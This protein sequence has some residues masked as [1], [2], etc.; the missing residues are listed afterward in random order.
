MRNRRA[1]D[2]VDGGNGART[3]APRQDGM[4]PFKNALTE[5][6]L[7]L[8]LLF[9]GCSRSQIFPL[10]AA[11]FLAVAG[12]LLAGVAPLALKGMID[13]ATAQSVPADQT[14]AANQLLGFS[15]AYLLCLCGARLCTDLRPWMLSS[16]EQG[17]YAHLRQRFFRHV[18]ALPLSAHLHAQGDA[19]VQI[20]QQAVS[21]YQVI[22]FNLAGSAVPILA[23]ALAASAVLLTLGQPALSG[24]FATT[25]FAYLS[26]VLIW[27]SRIKVA[28]GFVSRANFHAH[29]LMSDS[30]SNCEPLKCFGAE[31]WAQGKFIRATQELERAWSRLQGRRLSQALLTTAAFGLAMAASLLLAS[32]AL[33][34]GELSIGGFFLANLYMVQLIRLLE[35]MSSALRD[36]LQ[37]LAFIRPIMEV[38]QQ[39]RE[40]ESADQRRTQSESE[41]SDPR[42][43]AGSMATSQPIGKAPH[44]RFSDIHMAF[45]EQ[46]LVLDGLNLDIPAG[47]SIGIVGESGGGKSSLVRVLLR[48]YIPQA[49]QVF[50]DDVP[51]HTLPLSTLRSMIA[52]VPQDVVLFDATIADNIAIGREGATIQDVQEA[53][54][55]AGMH[56][57]ITSMPQAF[58]TRVGERGQRLSGGERQRVAMARA[59]LKSPQIFVFDEATSMLDAN[60]ERQI[61][62]DQRRVTAGRTSITIAHRLSVLQDL[63]QIAVMAD[64]RIVEQGKHA[65]LLAGGGIYAKMWRAQQTGAGQ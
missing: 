42:P 45:D 18:L 64:G 38:F 5:L 65:D 55:L 35:M 63:D 7:A 8:R 46:R 29:G 43:R 17:L 52:V 22:L 25:A 32:R 47:S 12:G 53:A 57:L 30:L 39:A 58:E 59:I 20:L 36:S 60:T 2:G 14:P 15:L 33:T 21:A 23:E 19:K 13:G 10:L 3:E 24:I 62:I 54:C 50:F 37:S 49:G 40:D 28:A 48:L 11:N 61:L 41:A 16:A 26:L 6:C 56:G 4:Q 9:T 34:S 31:T 1:N 51:I 44:I 27:S